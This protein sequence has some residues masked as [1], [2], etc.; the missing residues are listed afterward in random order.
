MKLGELI[1]KYNTP[2]IADLPLS[3]AQRKTFAQIARC[4]T[5]DLGGHWYLCPECGKSVLLFNSCRNRNCPT[6]QG[7]KRKIWVEKQCAQLLDVPYYH[8][9]FTLPQA[10]NSLFL[11]RP[12]ILYNVLFLAAWKTLQVFFA[13]PKFFGGTGAMLAVLHTWGQTLVLHPHLHCLV[14]GAGLDADGNFKTMRS[15]GKYLFPVKALSK[16]FRAKFAA[17]LT[18]QAKKQ[19]FVIPKSIR[20]LMFRQPWVVFCKRPFAK[21]DHVVN[22]LGRYTYRSAIADSRIILD[23]NNQITFAYK[24]YKTAGSKRSMTLDA[25]EFFRRFAMH[26]LPPR[27]VK[28]RHFGLLSNTHKNE[29]FE[30]AEDLKINSKAPEVV[31]DNQTD[32]N[33][34]ELFRKTKIACKCCNSGFMLK[35]FPLGKIVFEITCTLTGEVSRG[36]RPRDGPDN[37]LSVQRNYFI[38]TDQRFMV[39]VF[40]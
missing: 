32:D 16:V 34:D 17:E 8:V 24:D 21:P 28:I 15:N 35:L 23:E 25:G 30:K 26:V 36:N 37:V 33:E 40:N 4:R 5:A 20:A 6:C 27:T 2:I 9:V 39:S 7:N 38:G 13:D 10:L 18:R 22:Y 29:F 12:D 31:H 3:A 19:D 1:Q 14:P 11:Y